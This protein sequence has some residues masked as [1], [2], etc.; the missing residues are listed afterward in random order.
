MTL[1]DMRK[2]IR[3]LRIGRSFIVGTEGERQT[4]LNMAR[5]LGK[6]ITTRMRKGKLGG[7]QIIALE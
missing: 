3:S 5:H 4:A 7:F 1:E 6:R 2:T